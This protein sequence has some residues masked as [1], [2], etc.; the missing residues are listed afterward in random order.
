MIKK[1]LL[2]VSLSLSLL[3]T[4]P[5]KNGTELKEFNKYKFETPT[6]RQMKVPKRTELIIVAFTKDTG[7][8]ANT[9]LDSKNPYYLSSYHTIFVAD[10]HNMPSFVTTM[11]ALPKLREYKHP[12]YLHYEDEFENFIPNKDEEIIIIRLEDK[13]VVSVSFITTTAQLK[14]AI[15]KWTHLKP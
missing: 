6:G 4:N 5:V 9:Y 13:K 15:E 8:L 2:L 10:I 14:D 3:A 7:K 12:I 11:F 1:V